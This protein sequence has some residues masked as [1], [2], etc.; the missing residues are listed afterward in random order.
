MYLKNKEK[1]I[2]ILIIRLWY[3]LD[4]LKHSHYSNENY[5]NNVLVKIN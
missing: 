4:H 1:L 5:E 3:K 2:Y